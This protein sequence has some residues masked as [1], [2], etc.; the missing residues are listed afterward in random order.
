MFLSTKDAVLAITNNIFV[1]LLSL[2]IVVA[3]VM[4]N[5]SLWLSDDLYSMI[6]LRHAAF[7]LQNSSNDQLLQIMYFLLLNLFF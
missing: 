3:Y 1:S 4:K 2:A 6:L 5:E 7:E